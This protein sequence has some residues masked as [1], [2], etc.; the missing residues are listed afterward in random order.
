V[1]T[2]VAN[3]Y[4]GWAMVLAAFAT[5]AG[6]GVFFHREDFW[7]GYASFRRRIVR[8]G[9]IALAALGMMNVLYALCP[10]PTIGSWVE[11]G[12]SSCFI[13]GGVSMPAVCFLAGWRE[14]ARV[15]F[16]VPVT[17]LVVAVVLTL[18]GGPK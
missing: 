1:V 14:G 11:R 8:L 9:H 10:W 5:G 2:H 17:A 3:F 7:G 16:P 4:A 15:L 13:I 12:A 6:I 18:C